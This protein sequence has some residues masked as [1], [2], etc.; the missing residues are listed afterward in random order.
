MS[1]EQE[2]RTVRSVFGKELDISALEGIDIRTLLAANQRLLAF[3]GADERFQYGWLN[4]RDP[5]TSMKIRKGLWELVPEDDPVITP[6]AISEDGQ[7]RVSEMVAVRMPK[8]R[9]KQIKL[10]AV[11]LAIRRGQSADDVYKGNIKNI[12]SRINPDETGVPSVESREDVRV[13][14]KKK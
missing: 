12:A 5:L 6:G 14:G 3:E 8:D 1:D 7:R 10:A 13:G 11:A 2:K 9:Y 4:V